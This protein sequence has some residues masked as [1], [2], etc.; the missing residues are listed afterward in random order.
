MSLLGYFWFLNALSCLDALITLQGI[1]M[2]ILY[3]RNPIVNFFIESYGLNRGMFIVK[4]GVPILTAVM[5]KLHVPNTNI[6]KNTYIGL[7]ALYLFGLSQM[8]VTIYL[9]SNGP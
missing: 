7:I 5:F 1:E 8:T 6:V 2:G 4:A 3:E 9:A